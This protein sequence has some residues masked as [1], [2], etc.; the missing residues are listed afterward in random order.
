M[1]DEY[2]TCSAAT[3]AD[4]F[5]LVSQGV[6]ATVRELTPLLEEILIA[7]GGLDSRL[8]ELERLVEEL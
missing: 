5:D 1:C 4:V 8:D 6:E 3:S 2:G 7:V